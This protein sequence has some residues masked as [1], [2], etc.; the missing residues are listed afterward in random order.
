MRPN[1]ALKPRPKRAQHSKFTEATS[2]HSVLKNAKNDSNLTMDK[3]STQDHIKLVAFYYECGRNITL[4]LRKW[5]SEYKNRPKPNPDTVRK[6]IAR[7]EQTGSVLANNENRGSPVRVKTPDNLQAIENLVQKDKNLS[8]RQLALRLG[9]SVGS[10]WSIMREDLGIYPYKTQIRHEIPPSAIEKRYNFAAEM[11]ELIDNKTLKIKNIIFSDEAHFQLN[12]SVNSQNYRHWGTEKPE[13]IHEEPLHH[14]RVT[15]WCG[16]TA[17]GL[18]GPF[19]TNET[20]DGD[21]YGFLLTQNIIPELEERNLIKRKYF[22]QDGAPPHSTKENLAILNEA[23]KGRV[24]ARGFPEKFNKGM[25]WPPYSP[26]LTPLDFFLWGYLKDKVYRTKPRTLAGLRREIELEAGKIGPDICQR[27]LES[28]V[29][30]LRFI[31][32]TEGKHIENIIK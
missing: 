28:A 22:Q 12:G 8:I 25:A 21:F 31:I 5:S 9:I 15:V 14:K 32:A 4:T 1:R 23:F 16:L 3:Y 24:I 11:L 27:A 17:E 2:R 20:I 18:I 29:K 7:F 10:T 19:F 13:N 30:R 26:D 6:L